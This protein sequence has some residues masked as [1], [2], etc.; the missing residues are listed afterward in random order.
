MSRSLFLPACLSAISLLVSASAWDLQVLATNALTLRTA[1]DNASG[2][3][4]AKASGPFW[5]TD[6]SATMAEAADSKRL[7]VSQRLRRC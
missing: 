7:I 5:F 3:R 2:Q 4:D 6:L 1:V